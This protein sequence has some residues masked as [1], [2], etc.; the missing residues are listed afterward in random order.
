[1][2]TEIGGSVKQLDGKISDSKFDKVFAL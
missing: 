2:V 1:M